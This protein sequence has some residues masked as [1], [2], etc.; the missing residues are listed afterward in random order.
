MMSATV[1]LAATHL[2]PLAADDL[3][4]NK[5][6]PGVLG[7]IVFALLG[8]AVWVLMKSMNKHMKKVAFDE[9]PEGAVAMAA[10]ATPA[11][12]PAATARGAKADGKDATEG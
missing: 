7:F 9:I 2:V 6:T 12:A 5:V 10:T 11:T 1:S 4:K 3:D 8:A